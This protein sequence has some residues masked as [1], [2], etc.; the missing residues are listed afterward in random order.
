MKH[1]NIVPEDKFATLQNSSYNGPDDKFDDESNQEKN[2]MQ[3]L[4]Y[5]ENMM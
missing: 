1:Q 2:D 4:T 5:T 3:N